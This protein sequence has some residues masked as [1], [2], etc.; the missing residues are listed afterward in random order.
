MLENARVQE[1]KACNKC[2]SRDCFEIVHNLCEFT[3]KQFIKF[4]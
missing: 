4:Q 2:K 3:D 1:P